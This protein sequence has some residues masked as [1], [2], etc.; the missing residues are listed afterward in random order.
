MSKD[1]DQKP[2][3]DEAPQK[4]PSLN[5]IVTAAVSAALES[6]LPLAVAV[7][8]KAMS[9]S[10]NAEHAASAAQRNP[11]ASLGGECPECRQRVGA[12]KSKHRRAVVFPKDQFFA[13]LFPGIKINGVNY[14]SNHGS[15]E[16][17]VPAD[18]DIENQVARW[19]SKERDLM[20]PKKR[21]HNS[22]DV[23]R[24]TRDRWTVTQ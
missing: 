24:P 5:E 19:E 14:V 21:I 9:D 8:S 6:A 2:A 4:Q 12:C 23:S 17:S 15:H 7:A 22:G 3:Q 20:Q 18:C 13:D 1:K 16:L 10:R 11:A